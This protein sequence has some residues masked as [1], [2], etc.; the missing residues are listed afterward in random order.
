M[1]NED[2]EKYLELSKKIKEISDE[3]RILDN[4]EDVDLD[5]Q[6]V[7]IRDK[8][9]EVKII[10]REM[11]EKILK[12][13]GQMYEGVLIKDALSIRKG[14]IYKYRYQY[15]PSC[16]NIIEEIERR[17]TEV[18]EKI[19]KDKSEILTFL[20]KINKLLKNLEQNNNEISIRKEL[21]IEP[22]F[23]TDFG[24]RNNSIEVKEVAKICI[25]REGNHFFNSKGEEAGVYKKEF[26][27]E[28]KYLR[29]MEE[30]KK[31]ILEAYSQIKKDLEKY[32]EQIDEKG[33]KY[34]IASTL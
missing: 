7:K 2:I 1:K 26:I 25:D 28:K 32:N 33:A 29:E 6:G 20:I 4:E 14:K 24:Y 19:G 3:I 10:Q 30:M 5:T 12:I 13:I 16:S 11:E 15:K 34:L 31:S 18:E 23:L 17:Y 8:F 21:E 22:I 9:G 27:I